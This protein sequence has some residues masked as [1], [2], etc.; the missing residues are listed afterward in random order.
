MEEVNHTSVVLTPKVISPKN[1]S[2]FRPISLC[3]VIYKII[4]KVIVNR[5]CQVLHRCTD[6]RRQ[7]TNNIFVA[8]E[9]LHSFKKRRGNANR[10]FALKLD[11][12]KAYDKVEWC[13]TERLMRR[14]G[15]NEE[16]T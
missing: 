14:M 7:I 10:G 11:M 9:I 16:W 5:F 12:T 2:Q 3:N 13:F 15:F 6:D 4:S 1:I 8:Y